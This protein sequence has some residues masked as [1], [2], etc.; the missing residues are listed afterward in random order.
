MPDPILKD[1]IEYV[2]KDVDVHIV[3]NEHNIE[4]T[5]DKTDLKLFIGVTDTYNLSVSSILSGDTYSFQKL[6]YL[7][8]SLKE[9][10]VYIRHLTKYRRVFLDKVKCNQL[11]D[12]EGDCIYTKSS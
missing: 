7:I 3:Q 4:I 10:K 8:D 12:D 1:L 2:F 11:Y 6:D 5:H 9:Y